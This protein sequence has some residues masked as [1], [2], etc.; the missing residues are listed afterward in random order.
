MH[1]LCKKRSPP[2][3]GEVADDVISGLAVAVDLVGIDIS[4]K[5]D[6]SMLN[7]GQ[8]IQLFAGR[9]CLHTFVQ[10]LIAFFSR[11]EAASDIMSGH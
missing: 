1:C 9:T 7:S 10:Y 8:I 3:G 6:N 5:F 11:P 4:V 2:R